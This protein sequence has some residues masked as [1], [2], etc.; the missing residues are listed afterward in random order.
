MTKTNQFPTLY[1]LAKTGKIVEWD[2]WTEGDTIFTEWGQ[3]GGK[4]QIAQKIATPKNTGKANATTA[5]EQAVVEAQAMWTFNVERKYSETKEQSKEVSRFPMLAKNF[6]AKKLV[7]PADVQPKLDGVRC[8]AFWEDG[9]IKLMSRGGKEWGFSKHI[10]DALF[11]ILPK[12]WM[13]DGELYLHGKNLQQITRMVNKLRPENVEVQYHVY[14][15]P[16]IND[17]DSLSWEE[18]KRQLLSISKEFDSPI[19]MAE[20]REV[21]NIDEVKAFEKEVVED[22]YEGAIVRNRSGKYLFGYRNTDLMKVKSFEDA[23]FEVVGCKEGIGKFVGCA[24]FRCKNDLNDE[25]FDVTPACTFE[26]KQDFWNNRQKYIGKKYT[27]KFFG[28]KESGIPNIATGKLFRDR[29]DLG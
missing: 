16:I 9:K 3:E 6:N 12:G 14:D 11:D 7:F 10:S 28:R 18:R 22:G 23:E 21:K 25:E 24:I 19:I 15:V 5:E 4:K 26:E 13:F 27:V 2:I 17:D 8:L 29:K 1:H 20:T